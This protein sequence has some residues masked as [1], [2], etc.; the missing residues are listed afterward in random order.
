[1]DDR[2]GQ[3]KREIEEK[4]AE[5]RANVDELADRMRSAVDWRRQFRASP[6]L[7]LGLAFGGGLVLA[8]LLRSPPRAAPSAGRAYS[9]G[10]GQLLNAWEAIQSAVLGI[11]ASKVSD[12][13]IE[14]LPGFREHLAQAR[15]KERSSGNG[16]GVHGEGNYAASQRFRAAAERYVRTADVERA[17]RA[18]EPRDEEEAAD[19]EAAERAG[20][21]RA[22]SS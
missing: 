15:A 14:L 18:A 13:L 7:G 20:K 6:L 3:V 1:M 17:A 19:L 10:R 2:T 12:V 22:R 11:A 9:S 5:L 4:R 21:S 16:H 8:S